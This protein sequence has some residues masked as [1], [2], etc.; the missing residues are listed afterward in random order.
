MSTSASFIL[1]KSFSV[2]LMSVSKPLVEILRGST[3]KNNFVKLAFVSNA[4]EKLT[5]FNLSC[6]LAIFLMMISYNLSKAKEFWHK[7]SPSLCGA[8]DFSNAYPLID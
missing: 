8:G 5:S 3:A 6:P 2:L 4:I 1:V 7:K